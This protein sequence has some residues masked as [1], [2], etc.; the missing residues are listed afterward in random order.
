MTET[1]QTA[2][3]GRNHGALAAAA[4]LP[5]RIALAQDM[6]AHERAAP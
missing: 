1:T 5:A 3:A 6:P 4:I 2:P